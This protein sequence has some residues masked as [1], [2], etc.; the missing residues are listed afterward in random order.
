MALKIVFMGTPDFALPILKSIHKSEH[1]ILKVYTQNPKKKDRGQKISLTPVHEYSNLHQIEVS[2]PK[3]LDTE[4]EYDA[5]KKINPNVVV[6]VAYGKI[7]PE[8]FLNLKN[9]KFINIHAS[10]LPKWRGAAPIHRSIMNL[11]KETGISIMK[12]EKRLDAGPVM[13]KSTIKISNKTN[14]KDLSNKMSELSSKM[15]LEALNLLEKDEAVFIPQDDSQATYAKKILKEETKIDWNDEAEK[16][17]AKINALYPKPGAWFQFNGSRIKIIKAKEVTVKGKPG[18]ILD[19]N[20]TI[21]CMKN[22]IQIYEIQKEGKK[23]MLVKEFIKG[24]LFKVGSNI[25]K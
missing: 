24:N 13:M 15:I 3:T 11:D 8:K 4:K 17:I 20:L 12:I 23:S 19:K 22:G 25:S 10:L 9:I 16:I 21:A 18:E 6:V 14:Y 2:C 1:R 5:I 7:L